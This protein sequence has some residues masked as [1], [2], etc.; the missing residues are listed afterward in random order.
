MLENSNITCR[1]ISYRTGFFNRLCCLTQTVESEC[2][3][4]AES[5]VTE[6]RNQLQFLSSVSHALILEHI[7]QG[8]GKPK[9]K[10]PEIN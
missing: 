6:S 9:L 5:G 2:N 4:T 1:N 8:L 10:V 7:R 3:Y